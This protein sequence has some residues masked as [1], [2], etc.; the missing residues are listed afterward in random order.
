MGAAVSA[1]TVDAEWSA[2]FWGGGVGSTFEDFLS[3]IAD[4]QFSRLSF[5]MCIERC[6]WCV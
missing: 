3:S 4:S 5:C 1:V 6:Q 2:H